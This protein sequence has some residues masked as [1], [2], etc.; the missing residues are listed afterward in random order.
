VRQRFDGLGKYVEAILDEAR[1]RNKLSR[2]EIRQIQVIIFVRALDAFLR[3]GSEAAAGAVDALAEFGIDGFRVGS[4]R[5]SGRNDAVTRGDRLAA[6]L[7]TVAAEVGMP[8]VAESDF[9]LRQT[10]IQLAKELS[11][12]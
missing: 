3:Q 7:R 10:I 5:F 2:D 8:E 4:E 1:L 9:G 6:D 12:K 11:N